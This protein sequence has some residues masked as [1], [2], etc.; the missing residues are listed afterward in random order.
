MVALAGTHEGNPTSCIIS[1]VSF[2]NVEK[3]LQNPQTLIVGKPQREVEPFR[4]DLRA[5]RKALG[6]RIRELR[7]MRGW[8]QEDFA[9]RAHIHRTFAGSLERGEKNCSFHALVLISRCFGI[10]MSELLAGLETGD[11]APGAS[12]V[13]QARGGKAESAH[14]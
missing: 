7:M 14:R 4:D 9:S 12:V 11:L 10:T 1:N 13:S 8:S 6:H 2:G 3:R 5:F